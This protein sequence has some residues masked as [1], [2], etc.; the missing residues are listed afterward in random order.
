[1]LN[2]HIFVIAVLLFFSGYALAPT[3]HFKNIKWLTVY[4]YFILDLMNKHFKF[5]WPALKIFLII[6]VLNSFSL[7]LNLLSAWG[8][9]APLFFIVYL[10]INIGVIMYHTLRG[11]FYYASL[12]NPVALFELPAAW[13][14]ITMAIQFSLKYFFHVGFLNEIPFTRYLLYFVFTVIPL[15]CVAAIIEVYLIVRA[16]REIEE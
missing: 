2:F 8:I 4:P 5:H 14:S 3:A 9:I 10:G 6:F 1:M 7:F 16:R 13:I 12:L 15:L 11:R